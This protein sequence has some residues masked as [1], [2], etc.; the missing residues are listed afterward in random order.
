M[1]MGRP[2]NQLVKIFIY[3]VIKKSSVTSSKKRTRNLQCL[4]CTCTLVANQLASTQSVK[5][6]EV[7]T[8]NENEMKSDQNLYEIDT[9]AKKKCVTSK[10]RPY[11]CDHHAVY[12]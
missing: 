4:F 8:K 10:K 11:E 3:Q 5:R 9:P 2:S 7:R 6:T 1:S 12:I